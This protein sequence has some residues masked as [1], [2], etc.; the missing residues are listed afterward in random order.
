MHSTTKP[1]PLLDCHTTPHV[2]L[3]RRKNKELSQLHP[4]S[5]IA[6]LTLPSKRSSVL[7]S[8]AFHVHRRV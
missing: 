1:L 6:D 3:S 2:L 7:L 5:M 4:Y 8:L